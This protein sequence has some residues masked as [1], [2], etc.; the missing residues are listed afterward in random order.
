[1]RKQC[2]ILLGSTVIPI[3]VATIGFN[4]ITGVLGIAYYLAFLVFSLARGDDA[5]GGGDS[6]TLKKT[7]DIE[8]QPPI[9]PD[10]DPPHGEEFAH[11]GAPASLAYG[12]GLLL[13]GALLIVC[14]STP[15]IDAVGAAAERFEINSVL[16]AFFLAPVA[17]EMPE[18]LES[19]SLSRRGRTQSINIA[20]SN[21]V[22]GT[23]TK[24]TLLCAVFCFFGVSSGF[25][26]ESPSY[27]ISLALL[28][29]SA[30]AASLI[31]A[32]VTRPTK[33]HGAL[34]LLLFSVAGVIQYVINGR[35][36]SE[37][38]AVPVIKLQ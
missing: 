3:L 6:A 29:L 27:T 32:V 9:D 22:G 37:E 31:G 35:A 24:T 25:A 20:F 5:D 18:I 4:M 16:L 2:L 30:A 8:A 7:D 10:G 1:M 11:D 21:L 26:W 19:V 12:C 13:L 34:L 14:F 15:F 17:S 23:I 28:V 33:L 38:I 36:V